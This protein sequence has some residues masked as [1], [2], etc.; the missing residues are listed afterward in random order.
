MTGVARPGLGD[1]DFRPLNNQP[2]AV[3]LRPDRDAVSCFRETSV[4]YGIG[5][6]LKENE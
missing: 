5:C 4:F 6:Q 3:L 2:F 1:A